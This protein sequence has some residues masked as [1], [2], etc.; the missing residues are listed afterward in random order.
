MRETIST[1]MTDLERGEYEPAVASVREKLGAADFSKAWEEGRKLSM[2][3]AVEL[4]LKESASVE[5][6]E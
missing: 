6:K 3:S 1:W 5:V 4:A 2:D